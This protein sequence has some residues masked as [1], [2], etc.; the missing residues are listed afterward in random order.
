MKIK[1]QRI[2][3]GRDGEVEYVFSLSLLFRETQL[4]PLL[5]RVIQSIFAVITSQWFILR[6][7]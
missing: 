3:D 2:L 4:F 6:N 7:H 5:F 1:N